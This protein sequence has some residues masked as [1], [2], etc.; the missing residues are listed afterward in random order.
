[1]A[2][3]TVV[4]VARDGRIILSDNGA[5]THTVAYEDGDFSLSPEKA[6]RVVI[7]DRGSIVGL[8][9]GDDTVPTFSFS[10][11]HRDFVDAA[12]TTIIDVIEKTDSAS[13]W[14]STGGTGFEQY[15]VDLEFASEGTDHGDTGDHKVTMTKCLL[16]WEFSEGKDG[17]KISVS[18][19]VYGTVIRTES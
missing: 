16:N 3:S 2:R 11:Y 1:M 15:L 17:N 10:V 4:K 14:V 13:A 6:E 9:A 5:N 19:E 18:G 12:D 7:R 8:R